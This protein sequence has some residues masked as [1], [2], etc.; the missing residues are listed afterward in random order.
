MITYL[1]GDATEPVG[2]G[3][4]IITHCCNDAGGWGSGFVIAISK[5]WQ[6]PEH[7]YRKW[8]VDKDHDGLTFELGHVQLVKVKDDLYVCNMIG[9]RNYGR[10][11]SPDYP[12]IRYDALEK[13]FA[14]AAHHARVLGASIHMPRV[15]CGLAGG[16][17]DVVSKI[18]ERTCNGLQ[19]YVYD[20]A[21]G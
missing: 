17:W 15:G 21:G 10:R 5:R 20:L 8:F 13:C 12:F 16:N 14:K 4:K 3:C 19:V 18:V 2:D 9:Q 6:Q 1:K 7:A 11:S